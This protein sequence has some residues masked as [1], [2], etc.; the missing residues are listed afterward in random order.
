MASPFSRV[1]FNAR[2]EL[3]TSDLNRTE[4]LISRDL[5]DYLRDSGRGVPDPSGSLEYTDVA[6]IGGVINGTC[7]PPTLASSGTFDV[8]VGA[9]EGFFNDGTITGDNSTFQVMRWPQQTLTITTPDA[10]NTRIDLIVATPGTE[11]VNLEARNILLDPVARTVG[12]QSVPTTQ[13]PLSTLAVVT[14]SPGAT[15]LP[16]AVPAGSIALFEI[17]VPAAVLSSAT[18]RPVRRMW[19]RAAYPFSASYGILNGCELVI[20]GV[21]ANEATT[22]ASAPRLA[23][24][25][26]NRVMIDGE[27][28]SWG[29]CLLNG[30]AFVD[31]GNSPFT[32]PAPGN[33]DRPYYIYLCGGRYLPQLTAGS[34][35]A[36]ACLIESTVVPT[37][38]GYPSAPI[39]TPR[40]DTQKGALFVGVGFTVA[41]TTHRKAVY[42]EGDWVRPC[43]GQMAIGNTSGGSDISRMAAF[44]NLLGITLS[45]SAPVSCP[46]SPIPTTSTSMEVVALYSNNT[47]AQVTVGLL[48]SGS[49][50]IY[51]G[52]VLVNGDSGSRQTSARFKAPVF[53]TIA[54][55]GTADAGTGALHVAA[56]GFNMGVLRYSF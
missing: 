6:N 25:T 17:R 26:L 8:V 48:S 23:L 41:G 53:G 35:D 19:Q 52:A 36:P 42:F 51:G 32:T 18:F 56:C 54:A 21:P 29:P 14:G 33:N 45:T 49:T 4:S 44:N 24:S 11:S 10:T 43:T 22:D 1:V 38:F 34:P 2:E 13:N 9:G 30:G 7:L 15:P 31:T 5:Q 46:I 47:S 3:L 12:Q 55:S 20:G 37:S 50:T 28:L 16:P 40:G 39:T 27:I